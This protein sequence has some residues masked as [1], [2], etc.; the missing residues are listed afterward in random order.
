VGGALLTPGGMAIISA[1]FQGADR[2]AAVGMWSGLG[3]VAGAVGPFL[4]GWLVE[5]NWRAVFLV[6]LPVAA[7]IVAVAAPHVPE[8]RDP[9]AAPHL[10]VAGTVLALAGLGGLTY[11]L[12]AAGAVGPSAG[13]IGLGVGG[14]LALVVFVLVERG[15]RQPLMPTGLFGNAQFSA[16]NAVTRAAADDHDHAVVLRPG[17]CACPADRAAHPAHRWF[18]HLRSGPAAHAPDRAGRLVLD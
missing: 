3:G 14:V 17:G 18:A 2:A 9:D 8:S 12:T 13:V 5:W 7:L 15:S 1:S 11:A 10:D 6:N 4:G 16:I